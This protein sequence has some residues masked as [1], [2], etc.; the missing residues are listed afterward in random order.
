MRRMVVAAAVLAMAVLAVPSVALA[1]A[2]PT[3]T[4]DKGSVNLGDR[5]LVQGDNWAART[6]VHIELCG[7]SAVDLSADCDLPGASDAGVGQNGHFSMLLTVNRPPS[8]C[9]CVVRVT[10]A[11]STGEARVAIAV[12]G[13][14]TSGQP[15]TPLPDI[16]KMLKVSPL[17]VSGSDSWTAW[18]GAGS[19]RTLQFTVANVSATPVHDPPLS[20]T[21]GKGDN[22]TG[23]I[24][25]PHIGDLNPG[26]IRVM[27]VPVDVDTL[28]LGRYTV[29]VQLAGLGQ[30]LVVR[31]QISNYPWGL[32][33]LALLA[34]QG[35]LLLV[36]NRVRRR[37]HGDQRR[38]DEAAAELSIVA[39]PIVAKPIFDPIDDGTT[40]PLP[41]VDTVEPAANRAA[42]SKIPLDA[43]GE[44]VAELAASLQATTDALLASVVERS[45][46]MRQAREAV[47]AQ[48][49][50]S[51]AQLATDADSHR[52]VLNM[53]RNHARLDLERA[54]GHALEILDIAEGKARLLVS[55]AEQRARLLIERARADASAL[56]LPARPETFDGVVPA[57]RDAP[58]PII[59][60]AGTAETP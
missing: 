32:L 15:A 9:P 28:S 7:N 19:K 45:D 13:V 24:V 42:P 43:A 23:I 37:L 59:D 11:S 44:R 46:A 55:D 22:P 34:L 26:D 12:A 18:F 2:T 48:A 30:P 25:A 35:I 1:Q 17:R 54:D 56:L 38:T 57:R 52:S 50:S 36:R 16:S 27:R 29:K 3:A 39:E 4:V 47:D 41:R 14:P 5:V 8:N 6:V 20:I 40:A 51:L 31:T 53:R 33:V 10:D 60:L 21:Y 49:A 58:E